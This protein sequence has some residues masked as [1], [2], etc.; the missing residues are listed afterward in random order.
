MANHPPT[1]MMMTRIKKKV[2]RAAGVVVFA[3]QLCACG[4]SSPPAQP[5]SHAKPAINSAVHSLENGAYAVL[6]EATTRPA[7]ETNGRGRVVLTYDRRKYSGAPAD[8]PLTYV[9][10]DPGDYIPM[11]IEGPL[12]MKKDSQGKSILTVTLTQA[13]AAKCEVF[14]RAHL[15]GRVAM[16]VDGEIVTLHKIRSVVT[17]GKLQITRCT[18]DAC[19]IIRAKLAR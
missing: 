5:V 16:V 8:E 3:A 15:G 11:I 2:T 19:Q 10:I 14:T 1:T 4:C 13:A 17:E 7:A 9:E 18:D 6:G 12:E